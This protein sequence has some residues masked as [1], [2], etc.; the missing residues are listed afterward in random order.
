[1]II[2]FESLEAARTTHDGT[3]YQAALRA[4]GDGAIRD[5]RIVE[6]V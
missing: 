5:V 1:M 3:A 6:G 4:L 2:E